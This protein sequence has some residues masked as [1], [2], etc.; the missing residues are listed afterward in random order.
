MTLLRQPDDPYAGAMTL[1]V[2]LSDPH[3]WRR[4]EKLYGKIDTAARLEAAVRR[5]N[6][7]PARPDLVVVTGDL[8]NDGTEHEYRHVVE[9]LDALEVPWRAL[10]GNHDDAD[11][12]RRILEASGGLF[13]DG[14]YGWSRPCSGVVDLPGVRIVGLDTSRAGRPDGDLDDGD[15]DAARQAILDRPDV[16]PV[17]ALHHPPIPLGLAAMD[18]MRLHPDAAARFGDLIEEVG[19]HAVWCGHVHRA[20]A[21]P[22]RGAVVLSSPS[23]AHSLASDLRPDAPLTVSNEPPGL[24]VHRFDGASLTSHVL[25]I[26]DYRFTVVDH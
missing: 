19:V 3:V 16:V 5:V 17:V 15:L 18:G 2:Q 9:I 6:G 26:G 10:P 14:G 24:L 21:T 7:L 23:T 8:V 11:T 25:T 20:T 12:A 4:G 1:V 13:D 22:W